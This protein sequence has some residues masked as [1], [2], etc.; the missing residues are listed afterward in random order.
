MKYAATIVYVDDVPAAV[1]FYG[2]A[3]GFTVDF[4]TGD[5][6]AVLASE[7]GATISFASKDLPPQVKGVREDHAGFELWLA[8]E[9]VPG[10]VDKAVA[11]GA[12][13][14][15]EPT[16]KPWGQVVAYVRTPDGTLI[17]LGEPIPGG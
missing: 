4:S 9:D 8:T 17:E 1:D 15:S 11:E 7:S 14:V 10:A 13:L 5:D 12:E 6:Y 16:A 3:F 2:R